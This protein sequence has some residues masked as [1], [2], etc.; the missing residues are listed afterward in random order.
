MSGF[1]ACA[2]DQKREGKYTLRRETEYR[3][4]DTIRR[5]TKVYDEPAK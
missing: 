2:V 5:G 1:Q 4:R 3:N